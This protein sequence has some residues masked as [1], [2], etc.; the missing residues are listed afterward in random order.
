[1]K[2]I[3]IA[4]DEQDALGVL[5]KKLTQHGY[6]VTAVTN[7][8]DALRCAQQDKPDLMLLD[9]VMPDMDGYALASALKQDGALKGVPI[10]FI[11]GQDLLPKGIEKRMAE[12][13]AYN[14]IMKPCAFE[15]I[16]AKVKAALG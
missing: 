1:M 12:L 9:I 15:D 7:A 16:L 2:K 11:T 10:I 13:G 5:E 4:D 8:T 14:Y 3:L 6:S